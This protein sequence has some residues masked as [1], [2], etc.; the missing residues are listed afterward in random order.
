MAG[1][2]RFGVGAGMSTFYR[3][4]L[5]DDH[6]A[7]TE[8]SR[9][10]ADHG[11]FGAVALVVLMVITW[12]A[13]ENARGPWAKAIVSALDIWAFLF[14]RV[15]AMRLAAPSVLLGLIHAQFIQDVLPE[16]NGHRNERSNKARG[17]VSTSN[18]TA[19]WMAA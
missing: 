11:T 1:A 2:P 5:G 18:T 3:A 10:V 17:R 16:T 7:H 12:Q 13:F 14:M 19:K 15:T 9:L 8:Y 6:A 4:K